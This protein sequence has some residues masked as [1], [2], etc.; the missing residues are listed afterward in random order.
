MEAAHATSSRI[1]VGGRFTSGMAMIVG[2]SVLA[3]LKTRSV[4]N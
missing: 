3:S 4:T 1:L 2:A